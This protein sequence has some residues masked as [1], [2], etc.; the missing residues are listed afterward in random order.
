MKICVGVLF[1]EI[2][3]G[4]ISFESELPFAYDC[5]IAIIHGKRESEVLGTPREYSL[6][7]KDN[8]SLID[9]FNINNYIIGKFSIG[10]L[11]SIGKGVDM[12]KSLE[13]KLFLDTA[14]FG[15]GIG[16]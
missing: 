4:T 15:F 2:A 9:D 5:L 8:L 3:G 13:F 7:F 10:L 1:W 6:I 14:E 11:Y 12:D 16:Q